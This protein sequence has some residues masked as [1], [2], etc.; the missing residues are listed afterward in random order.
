MLFKKERKIT[1]A[2]LGEKTTYNDDENFDNLKN[3][4]VG[5]FLDDIF[6]SEDEH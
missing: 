1:I 6:D 3:A 4:M 5:E 2:E